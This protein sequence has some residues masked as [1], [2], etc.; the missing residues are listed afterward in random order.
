MLA[1]RASTAAAHLEDPCP[2]PPCVSV[3]C[4]RPPAAWPSPSTGPRSPPP[5]ATATTSSASGFVCPKGASFGAADADPDR[6][7]S[8]LVRRGG[9]LREASW[10]EAFDAVA[11][12]IRPVVERY[13]PHAVGV[14]L[15][16]PN[17]HTMAGALYPPVLLAAL[18][19]PQRLHRLH[20][21]PDAQ[22]RLQR[23]ALRR[24]ATPS[25][26]PTSTA[27]TTSS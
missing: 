16:N 11:A 25:P 4:A 21:G 12:G 5:A 6:L 26:S 18:R 1:R 14:V 15:G 2:A 17:V 27:P 10:E 13:G 3:P 22:A 23:A 8:P 19:H 7:R 20:G 9:E 24:R